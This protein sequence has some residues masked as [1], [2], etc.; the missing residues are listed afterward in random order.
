MSAAAE[1]DVLILGAGGAG[2]RCAIHAA[3]RGRRVVVV[4]HAKKIGGQIL[5]PGG[6]RY[7]LH[8]RR[9]RAGSIHSEES[10][11]LEI[12]ALALCAGGLRP[13]GPR[14]WHSVP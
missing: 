6:G 8:E 4:D 10:A 5:I 3:R 12:R 14:S 13:D 11:L 7:Q 9:R 1:A 2:L